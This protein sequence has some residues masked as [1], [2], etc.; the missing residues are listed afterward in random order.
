[1]TEEITLKRADG[2]PLT[3][4]LY[5]PARNGQAVPER[6]PALFSVYADVRRNE[7]EYR[8]YLSQR[9]YDPFYG[10]VLSDYRLM[11]LLVTSW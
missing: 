10:S 7:T 3:A 8:E 11:A 6:L 9:S 5:R 2:L 1:V 4:R